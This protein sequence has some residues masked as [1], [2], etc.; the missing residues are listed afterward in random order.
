[1][2]QLMSNPFETFQKE[3]FSTE[4]ELRAVTCTVMQKKTTAPNN[5]NQ[6]WDMSLL[7]YVW[8]GR[9]YEQSVP[10]QINRC[11]NFSEISKY[12]TRFPC[13]YF[14]FD[15]GCHTVQSETLHTWQ[16]LWLVHY[17]WRLFSCLL[18]WEHDK[19]DDDL[20][21]TARGSRA[22][23][24]AYSTTKSRTHKCHRYNTI[25][26]QL[27]RPAAEVEKTRHFG[28]HL[29]LDTWSLILDTWSGIWYHDMATR[30]GG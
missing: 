15:E 2:P 18:Q 22:S 20:L 7:N 14:A 9:A 8:V 23:S 30:L 12:P 5:T 21:V 29:I 10:K 27:W 16:V 24:T 11:R 19:D 6:C 3:Q 4:Y 1:M 25:A 28:K 13:I 17:K 26:C